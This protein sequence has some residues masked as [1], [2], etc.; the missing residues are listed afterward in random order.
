MLKITNV[1]GCKYVS[2][3]E[4]ESHLNIHTYTTLRQCEDEL[5]KRLDYNDDTIHLDSLQIF[6][7]WYG[8]TYSQHYVVVSKLLRAIKVPKRAYS[9]THRIHIAYKSKYRCN[10]CDMLLPPEFEVDHIV[11]LHDGGEDTYENC[12]ALCPNCHAKKTR[13]NVLK[14]SRV[15]EKE[16]KK[17]SRIMEENAFE[18]FKC[19]K[20]KYF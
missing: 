2:F 15:F 6:L 17:R 4:L 3:T 16:F 18:K 13:A 1:S 12:Q 19:K 14:S 7:R 10:M 5:K 11:E 9:T 20:S 8:K